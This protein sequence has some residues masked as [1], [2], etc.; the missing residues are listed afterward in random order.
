MDDIEMLQSDISIFCYIFAIEIEKLLIF[1]DSYFLFH[2]LFDIL[3]GGFGIEVYFDW[4]FGWVM[5]V[6]RNRS[7]LVTFLFVAAKLR[8]K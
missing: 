2:Y 8:G 1:P 4:F 6:D 3:D 7:V 5:Q